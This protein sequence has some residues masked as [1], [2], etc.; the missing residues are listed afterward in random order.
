M[1]ISTSA[2]WEILNL[3]DATF[4]L[5]DHEDAMVATVYR[6]TKPNGEQF[7]LKNL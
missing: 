5:I 2:Y 3:P 6:I 4:S 7:V 1:T